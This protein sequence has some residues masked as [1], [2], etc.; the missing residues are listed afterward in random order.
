M[1]SIDLKVRK[2]QEV[3]SCPMVSKESRST[4]SSGARVHSNSIL[5]MNHVP[6]ICIILDF[7]V[8]N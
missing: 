6:R 4:N 2:I 1:S 7:T 5:A 3:V 8:I